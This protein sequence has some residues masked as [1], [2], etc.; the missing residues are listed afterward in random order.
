MKKGLRHIK[1]EYRNVTSTHAE[2]KY[3]CKYEYKYGYIILHLWLLTEHHSSRCLRIGREK[4]PIDIA[5]AN[6]KVKLAE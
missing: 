2:Y 3:K 6:E 5:S 1:F 4:A